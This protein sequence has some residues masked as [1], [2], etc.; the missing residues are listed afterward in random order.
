MSRTADN[1][2]NQ[3]TNAVIEQD[4]W[5]YRDTINFQNNFKINSNH[6]MVFGIEKE[7]EEMRYNPYDFKG[8][9]GSP[10]DFKR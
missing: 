1:V 8:S 6:N 9:W 5:S 7:F 3:F 10:T 2:V 4:Y